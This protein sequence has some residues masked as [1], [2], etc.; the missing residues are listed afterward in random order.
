MLLVADAAGWILDEV[1]RQLLTNMPLAIGRCSVSADWITAR[2][3][4][5]HFIDRAW[6]W[7]DGVLD[8]VDPSN[9]LITVW[10]HGR[11]D[12]PDPIIQA[13]LRRLGAQHDRFTRLQVTCSSGRQT[14]EALGVPSEKIVT[15]PIGVDLTT[16]RPSP[17]DQSR[18]VARRALGVGDGTAAV[19]CFQ[20]DGVGWTDGA[21]PKLIKGP[22]VLV[23]ALVLLNDR[24]PIHVVIPGPARG[25]VKRRLKDAGVPF[26][27]PGMVV[28]EGLPHLYHALDLYLSPSRDEGG[29]AGVLEAMASGVP[30]VSSRSGIPAD[31]IDHGVNGLLVDVGDAE[32][33][34]SAA[35]VLLESHGLRSSLAEGGLASIQAYDWR[36]V[37]ERYAAELYAPIHLASRGLS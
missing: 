2:D 28:R 9:R 12:S 11:L 26:S 15:L 32:A 23:D 4:T 30:V 16:F 10:W 5:L 24:R 6:A 17:G 22:D 34:A 29:P 21:E 8:R 25:Y 33:L 35:D 20:K 7:N 37:A 3:C 13:S 1:A 36:V 27:A 19:G 31:L 18:S 14:L